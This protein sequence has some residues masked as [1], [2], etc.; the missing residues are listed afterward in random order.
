MTDFTAPDF[1]D[2]KQELEPAHASPETLSLLAR[3]RST[4]AKNMT[5]PGPNGEQ[6]ETLLKIGAR[7]PDHGKLF[8]WRFVIFEGEARGQFGEILEKRL[9]EKEPDGPPERYKLERNRFLRAPVVVAVI[10]DVTENHKIPEWEQVLS[11]GAVCQTLLVAAS[12]M[13]FAAQ[14]LT[15]WYAYDREIKRALGLHPGERVAG[16]IY[17]GSAAQNPVERARKAARVSHWQG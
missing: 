11:A 17:V 3:R 7:T 15:E 12:A 4:L 10:S 2:V 6:L 14:W 16:F 13:G 9:R 5:G 1:P 8:P